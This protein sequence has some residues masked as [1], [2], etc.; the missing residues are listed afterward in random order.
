M[1]E[2]ERPEADYHKTSDYTVADR[3]FYWRRGV[4]RIRIFENLTSVPI[5][6]ASPLSTEADQVVANVTQYLSADILAKHFTHRL[7]QREPMRWIEEEVRLRRKRGN[8]VIERE[9]WTVTFASFLPKPAKVGGYLMSQLT[10]KNRRPIRTKEMNQIL[11]PGW[12]V[13]PPVNTP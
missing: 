6:I 1:S 11:G 5:V 7:W 2:H 10:E 9:Y 4:F 3:P 12:D 13:D 8:E